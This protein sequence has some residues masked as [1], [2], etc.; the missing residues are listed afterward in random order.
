MDSDT[1]TYVY[2]DISVLR[3]TGWEPTYNYSRSLDESLSKMTV[4]IQTRPDDAFRLIESM[5]K[6]NGF[7]FIVIAEHYPEE[8]YG[9]VNE[10][11]SWLESGF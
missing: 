5:K 11:V 8:D 1:E 7:S 10:P 3:P 6:P 9:P 2:Y 4:M